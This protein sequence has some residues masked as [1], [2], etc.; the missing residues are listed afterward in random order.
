MKLVIQKETGLGETCV[1]EVEGMSQATAHDVA[2]GFEVLDG[3]LQRHNAKVV[4]AR[5]FVQGIKDP[6]YRYL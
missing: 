4:E 3:R 5:Q 1:V 6:N 2:Y